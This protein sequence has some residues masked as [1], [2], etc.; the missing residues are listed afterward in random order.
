MSPGA[1]RTS[2]AAPDQAEGLAP[3]A[4]AAAT[5]FQLDR[6]PA[7][8]GLRA[9]L[10]WAVVIYHLTSTTNIDKLYG[11]SGKADLVGGGAV[12]VFMLISGFV[13]A[14]LLI[15]RREDWGS[16]ITRRAF[17]LFPVYWLALAIAGVCMYLKLAALG[18]MSWASDPLYAGEITYDAN[19]IAAVEA[20][21]WTHALLH[22]G[23]LQGLP[24]SSLVPYSEVSILGPAWTLTVEWQFYLVAPLLVWLMRRQGWAILLLAAGA[25]FLLA[26]RIPAI[27]HLLSAAALPRWLFLFNIGI[28]SRIAMPYLMRPR[29]ITWA[30]AAAIL[31]LSILFNFL[32]MITVWLA[33][34]ALLARAPDTSWLGRKLNAVFSAAFESP[35]AT[36]LGARS[37]SVYILHSPIIQA[38]LFFVMPLYAFTRIEAFVVMIVLTV[39]V[40][41]IASGLA[42]RFVELP[43]IALGA[44][45]VAGWRQRPAKL[46]EK[47]RATDEMALGNAT[48]ASLNAALQAL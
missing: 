17:R 47:A 19:R 34:V 11:F 33:F 15:K 6:I 7:I 8:E 20:A 44:R 14:G 46:A 21:P 18:D 36:H 48:P 16:Y 9:W 41:L 4:I 12:H 5:S 37:Y 25:A 1:E 2:S 38:L 22:L 42:Y 26:P 35:L 31:S 45:V 3:S 28:A 13:I 30:V 24:P 23:L 10:A 32:P 27:D 40:V 29:F 39:P 43:M